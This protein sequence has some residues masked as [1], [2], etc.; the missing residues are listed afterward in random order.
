MSQT[1]A[2]DYHTSKEILK[3]IEDVNKNMVTQYNGN[4]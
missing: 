4:S 2:L 3:L 1:G